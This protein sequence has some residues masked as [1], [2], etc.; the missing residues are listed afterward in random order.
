[1]I[2]QEIFKIICINIMYIHAKKINFNKRENYIYIAIIT[3]LRLKG[4][5]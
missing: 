3:G 1:M 5:E 2:V 4:C